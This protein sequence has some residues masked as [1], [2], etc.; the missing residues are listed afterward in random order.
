M[1]LSKHIITWRLLLVQ[2][3]PQTLKLSLVSLVLSLVIGV[4]LGVIRSRRWVIINQV[5]A[6]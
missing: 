1:E 5:L 3:L 6:V 4:I 2:G